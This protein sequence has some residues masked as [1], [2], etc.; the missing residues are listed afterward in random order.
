MLKKGYIRESSSPVA[1]S[2]FFIPK[3]NKEDQPV[4]N[5]QP[6]NAQTVKDQTLLLLITEL[7]DKLEGKKIFT[8]LDLKRVYNLIYIKEG[9]K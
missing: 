6:L 9:D 2:M 8:V 5:Y 3:K 7:K 1:S 4:I